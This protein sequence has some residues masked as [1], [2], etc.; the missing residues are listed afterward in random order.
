MS[1]VV[2]GVLWAKIPVL[3]I[4]VIRDE[5]KFLAKFIKTFRKGAIHFVGL[6]AR[7]SVPVNNLIVRKRSRSNSLLNK[8]IE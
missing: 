2:S 4:T 5:P 6:K 8:A 7:H 3:K 1:S